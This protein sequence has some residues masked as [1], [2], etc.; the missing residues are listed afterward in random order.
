MVMYLRRNTLGQVEHI[1]V[2]T[3]AQHDMTACGLAC[4]GMVGTGYSTR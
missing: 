2:E 3:K 4:Y 1:L